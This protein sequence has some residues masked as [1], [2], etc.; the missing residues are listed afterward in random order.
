MYTHYFGIDESPFS[1]APDPRYL[2][3]SPGH[4]EALAHLLYGVRAGAGFVVLTGEVGTGK[5]TLCRCLLERLPDNVD[6]ALCLNP[7][8]NEVEL[9]ASVC[10][11]LDV[12]YPPAASLKT[13]VDRLNTHLLDAHARGRNSVLVID[14]AQNLG[15]GVLEQLRLLTNLETT[16]KKLLQII[17]IGQPEL[18]EMLARRD[19]RPLAQRITAR[20]HLRPL[21]AADTAALIAHRMTVAGLDPALIDAGAVAVIHKASGGVPRLINHLCERA[22]LAAYAAERGHVDRRLARAA[23]REVF[24]EPARPSRPAYGTVWLGA[25]AIVLAI[26]GLV[27]FD[28]LD[29]DFAPTAA[30]PPTTPPI[31]QAAPPAA[32]AAPVARA[33]PP[34]IAPLPADPAPPQIRLA[35][36]AGPGPGPTATRAPDQASAAR[37]GRPSTPRVSITPSRAA[38]PRPTPTPTA[39]AATDALPRTLAKL[40]ALHA[41]LTLAT[42]FAHPAVDGRLERAVAALFARWGVTLDGA[43]VAPCALAAAN[44]LQCLQGTGDWDHLRRLDRPAL[45]ALSGPGG[46]RLHA[47]ATRLDATTVGLALGDAEL[48]AETSSVSPYWSGDYLVL[49][50][51]PPVYK[52]LLQVGMRGPDVAWLRKR[53]GAT[54]EG[55]TDLFDAPLRDRVVTFQRDHG[56][57]ADGVVGPLTLIT[58]NTA[59]DDPAI[60]RLAP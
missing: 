3:L 40:K 23:A 32:R 60:P 35:A 39:L 55:S 6:V 52:V 2:Y 20:Y 50:R 49:W 13:L 37:P 1:I 21:S 30:H 15:A 29:L 7:R 46:A 9:L 24:G 45:I 4:E 5:T 11:E 18:G 10:D 59:D 48:V 57:E 58:L 16:T 56:L 31:A 44:G 27:V 8:L 43:A 38:A 51:P 17:L 22:L 12:A 25:A 26:T 34:I 14:E 19:M 28:P 36:V 41:P 42:V 33:A 47:V 54:K 53:L